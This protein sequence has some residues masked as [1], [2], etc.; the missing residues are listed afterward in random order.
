MNLS[1]LNVNIVGKEFWLKRAGSPIFAA[2]FGLK[3]GR[4]R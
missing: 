3:H 4:K 2:K 1:T